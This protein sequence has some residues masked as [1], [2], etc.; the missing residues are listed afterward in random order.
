MP[1]ETAGTGGSTRGGLAA[2]GFVALG[3]LSPATC[4]GNFLTGRFAAGRGACTVTGGSTVL[5]SWALAA[6]GGASSTNAGTIALAPQS[7]R[8]RNI[9]SLSR[10]RHIAEP[11]S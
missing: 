4:S 2:T 8:E 5:L 1:A 7:A 9:L 10:R 11:C 3:P 6:P